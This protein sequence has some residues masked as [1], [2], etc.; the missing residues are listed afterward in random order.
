MMLVSFGLDLVPSAD[1]IQL[2]LH[3]VRSGTVGQQCFDKYN[4]TPL[5]HTHTLEAAAGLPPAGARGR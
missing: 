2:L 4:N 5:P 1:L 3:T